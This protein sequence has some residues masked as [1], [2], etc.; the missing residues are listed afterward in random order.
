MLWK[1]KMRIKSKSQRNDHKKRS[2]RIINVIAVPFHQTFECTHILCDWIWMLCYAVLLCTNVFMSQ[3]M[4]CL[5]TGFSKHPHHLFTHT[6]FHFGFVYFT[7]SIMQVG[8]Q[9]SAPAFLHFVDSFSA[10]LHGIRKRLCACF[11][12]CK[13]WTIHINFNTHKHLL[14]LILML[15]LLRDDDK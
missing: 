15:L 3:L 13:H 4:Y 7:K 9:I 1:P 8:S 14:R 2:E 11:V 5:S 10:P 6:Y 12:P